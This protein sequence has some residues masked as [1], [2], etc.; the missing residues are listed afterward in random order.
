MLSTDIHFGRAAGAVD[1]GYLGIKDI[2]NSSSINI[3]YKLPKKSKNNPAPSL[4]TEEKEY[5]KYVSKNR[6]VVENAIA[7][8]KRYNILVSKFRNKTIQFADEMI[9]LSAG[10]WNLKLTNRLNSKA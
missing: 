1:L 8:L 7:G 2:W 6:V 4:T 3:P 9:E 10:L 5:N